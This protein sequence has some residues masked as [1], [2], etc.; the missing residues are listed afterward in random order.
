MLLERVLEK[1]LPRSTF[2]LQLGSLH[3]VPEDTTSVPVLY[4]PRGADG[5]DGGFHAWLQDRNGQLLDPSIL[6]TL[7]ADGYDVDPDAYILSAQGRVFAK[8]GLG[9]A[10]EE[11]A[12]LELLGLEESD[13]ALGRL[14]VVAM[15]GRSQ[16]PCEVKL[17]VRWRM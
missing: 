2:S 7:A 17:D 13:V 6:A 16:P 9:F 11:L 5:I 10:Y 4:D 1:V 14:M 8:F 3:V 12:D 15:E